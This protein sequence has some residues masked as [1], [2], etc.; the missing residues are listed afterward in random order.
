MKKYNKDKYFDIMEM[1][2]NNYSNM[3]KRL[4]R[5]RKFSEFVLVFYSISLIV[6]PL[7]AEFYPEYFNSKFSNYIGIV[8][9][10]VTLAYSL[11]N[12]NAKYAERID[13]AEHVMNC[14]KTLKRNLK[15]KKVKDIGKEYS[16]IVDSAES[17]SEIDF[18][19]TL[20]QKC[21][22]NNIRWYLYKRDIKKKKEEF[23]KDN[24]LNEYQ[25]LNNYLSENFPYMQQ[26]KIIFEYL[27]Y[28]IILSVPILLFVVCF[29]V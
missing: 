18:F 29:I 7:T 20:K 17:R 5:K 8:L 1:T 6:Y 3:M 24:K 21:K 10:I 27:W 25:K 23:A 19:R 2:Q 11:I 22:E 12:G 4:I 15:E 9:S 28:L 26:T 13:E 16:N 14:I